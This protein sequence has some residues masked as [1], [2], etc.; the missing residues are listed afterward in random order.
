MNDIYVLDQSFTLKGIIDSYESVIWRP[1]YSEVGDF[2]IYLGATV[3]RINLLRQNYYVVRSSDIT[4]E[5]GVTT[6]K[7]VMV[8]KNIELTTN[9]E[10]GDYLTVT[11]RE[12]K[13]LLHSRIVWKMTTLNGTAENA[14]RTLV[15]QNAINPTD[16]K[17]V[18][19]TL[20][21]AAAIG[22]TDSIE[23]QVTG[24]YLD[25]TITK[26]C[27]TY[28]YGW[29]VYISNGALV[30]EL[31][32][33]LD[34]SY[35]QSDRPYVVFSDDFDNLY[36]TDYQLNTE[37]YANCTLIGGEGEG[38]ERKYTSVGT[39]NSGL[40]R[41]EV[42]TDARDISSD[43][44]DETTIPLAA[45][46]LLLQQRGRENLAELAYTEGFSGEV[47]SNVAFKYGKDFY[48]GDMVTVINSYG[49]SKN[50]R[51]LSAIE[52]E[53]QSGTKLIPQFNI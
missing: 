22:L 50:V 38:A 25:D 32:M 35:G 53:D 48:I 26:I 2:E 40:N 34:R 46:L 17:R 37:E 1:S 43:G 15:N 20:R 42:F 45:Y 41:Y 44:E 39:N 31:Y 51:V 21:L 3:E 52:S 23:M 24:N 47:L 7:R 11:G 33:G 29:D 4:V 19:P 36:N 27:T 28:N 6:Y 9:V 5:N 14:I 16:S 12:L 49:I 10:D 18:I 8:I 13:F 30:F